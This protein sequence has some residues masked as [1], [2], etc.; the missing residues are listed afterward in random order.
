MPKMED[1]SI[2]A[3][4]VWGELSARERRDIQKEN[5]FKVDRN[6]AIRALRSRGVKMETIAE[7]TGIS[8]V[9]IK[10]I[11]GKIKLNI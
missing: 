9:Q 3:L 4:Q 6:E 11:A 2:E 1:L 5:P 10:R 7:V 8:L